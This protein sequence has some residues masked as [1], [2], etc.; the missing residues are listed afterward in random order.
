MGPQRK[1]RCRPEDTEW[2]RLRSLRTQFL[3]ED[4]PIEVYWTDPETLAAY[5]RTFAVR[6]G[7]KWEA[8]FQELQALG[9]TPPPQARLLDWGCGTGI[10]ARSWLRFWGTGSARQIYLYDRSLEA[11]QYAAKQIQKEFGQAIETIVVPPGELLPA[12]EVLLVSHVLNELDPDSWTELLA[13][14]VRSGTTVWVEP[15]SHAVSRKLTEVREE[16]RESLYLLA[17]C[18][19][20]YRCGLLE[21]GKESDWCH[22]FAPVPPGV[23]NDPEW[24]RFGR[25]L[26][27]D[28]RALPYAYLVLTQE[29]ESVSERF[30]RPKGSGEETVE[31][32]RVL[33]R[34]H[35][36]KAFIEFYICTEQGVDRVRLP[37]RLDST[38]YHAFRKKHWPTWLWLQRK[39]NRITWCALAGADRNHS[40]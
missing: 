39:D 10:A 34:P 17:P 20:P 28:L 21:E 32:A 8:V 22:F 4:G 30:H 7:W 3:Q 2:N 27:I 25:E 13:Q 19:H 36:E 33:G 15:G 14:T 5:D 12:T 35:V 26:G 11:A 6:I 37:R 40:S 38:L 18:P 9:W 24:T 29:K 1:R 31:L 23:M 16:L